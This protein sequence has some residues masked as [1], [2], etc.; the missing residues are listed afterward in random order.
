MIE[1][2]GHVKI[3]ARIQR[4]GNAYLRAAFP[5]LDYLRTARLEP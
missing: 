5:E 3:S 4:E 2:I 1:R